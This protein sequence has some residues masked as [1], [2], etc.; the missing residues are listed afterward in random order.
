LRR[1]G[2]L[3]AAALVLAACG[4]D[5]S[6]TIQAAMNVNLTSPD[7][8]V[9]PGPLPADLGCSGAGRA[10]SMTWSDPPP[11]TRS[12][13]VEMVDTEAPNGVF[14]HWLVYDIP[15]GARSLTPPL[16]A[17]AAQGRNDFGAT[18]YGG[19]CPPPGQTHVYLLL[20]YATTLAPTLPAGLTRKQL[21]DRFRDHVIGMGQLEGT[22]RR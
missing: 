13:V 11:S 10:P 2:A 8:P 14:T 21:E 22:Y 1:L 16:P 7:F 9:D 15:S 6:L 3:L 12:L 5:T 19:P 17:T 4:Q 20:L 18:G